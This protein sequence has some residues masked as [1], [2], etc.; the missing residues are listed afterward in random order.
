MK[1]IANSHNENV[2][3]V[4][5]EFSHWL[6]RRE[7]SFVLANVVG[8]EPIVEKAKEADI[9][10]AYKQPVTRRIIESLPELKLIMSSGNGYEHINVEAATEAGIPVTHVPTY[11][12]EDVAE[13]ALALILAMAVRLPQLMRCVKTGGWE[14]GSRIGARHRFSQ[15]VLG[16]VGFGRIGRMV[17]ERGMNLRFRIIAY[18]P[19]VAPEAFKALGVEPCGL[20]DLLARSDIVSLHSLVTKETHHLIAEHELR[21]MKRTAVL[22]NTSRG[23]LIN[24]SALVRALETRQLSGAAL[25]VLEKEPPEESNPLLAMDNVSV[26]GHAA[27][28]TLEGIEAWQ[29]GWRTIVEDFLAGRPLPNV[30]NPAVRPRFHLPTST[31]RHL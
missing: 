27:G 26:T 1:L 25:D 23:A 6:K 7:V 31:G 11:N 14:C 18:D 19:Y 15:Q 21:L 30:V 17:A 16:L 5:D 2:R 10:L 28:T 3:Y 13:H 24:E 12:V 20:E 4:Y 8:E 9:Y 29:Q 22:V